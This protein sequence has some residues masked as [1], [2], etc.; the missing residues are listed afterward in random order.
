MISRSFF[1]TAHTRDVDGNIEKQ[2]GCI[3]TQDHAMFHCAVKSYN[4]EHIHKKNGRSAQYAF[5]CCKENMC[6]ENQEFPV[7]P[8]PY[9]EGMFFKYVQI[10]EF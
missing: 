9:K 8:E 10:I 2:K 1:Q 7:L 4:G 5:E 3:K 6:N